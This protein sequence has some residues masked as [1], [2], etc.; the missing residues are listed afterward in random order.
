VRLARRKPEAVLARR[1][2]PA[3]AGTERTVRRILR[4][5]ERQGD[6]ALFYWT[7]Q[8]DRVRLTRLA[9]EPERL[10]GAVDTLAAP[11]RAAL[12]RAV[13]R[14]RAFHEAVAPPRAVAGP[15]TDGVQGRLYREPL[16]RVAVYVPAGRWPLPSSVV[17]GVVPAQVAGVREI[18]VFSPPR[19]EGE[20]DSTTLAAAA[21]LGV[22]EVYRVGGAQAVGAAAYGTASIR[23]VDKLVGPG[24][25]WV[26]EAK[27]QVQG[28]IGIDGLNGPSEVVI[29]AEAPCDPDQVARDLL[30]QAEHDPESWALAVST[31]PTLLDAIAAAAA[32][33]AQEWGVADLLGQRGVGAVPVDGPEAALAFVEAFAPEH[34]ELWGR[35]ERWRDAV[36]RAGAVFVGCP[37]PLGDYV[38]GPNHVLPTGGTAR[39]AS[40]LGVDD[41]LRRRTEITTAGASAA[42]VR[43]GAVLAA[44]E[45]LVMH[46]RALE[47]F[48]RGEAVG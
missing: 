5:V 39:F 21:L 38:A 11:V 15:M 30:A 44:T 4:T 20:V 37:T 10:A 27:R 47:A 41:F 22:R 2:R 19:R 13:E 25:R 1:A 33:R 18:A 17:M 35:A 26:T 8:L 32:R 3:A 45:G 12:E 34:L 40:V 24:N 48:A 31:D 42:V 28:R 9:V 43:A 7:E 46:Q 6:E 23:R 29:W 36:R 14:V 16:D